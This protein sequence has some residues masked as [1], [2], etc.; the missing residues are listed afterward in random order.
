MLGRSKVTNGD[1]QHFKNQK[2]DSRKAVQRTRDA[3]DANHCDLLVN[4]YTAKKTFYNIL[5]DYNNPGKFAWFI[6]IDTL[7]VFTQEQLIPNGFEG[8]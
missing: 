1:R 5:P 7:E 6:D 4:Y 2:Y 8:V 3:I